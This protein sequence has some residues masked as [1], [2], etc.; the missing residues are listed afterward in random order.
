MSRISFPNP[1]DTE[2]FWVKGNLHTHTTNSDG[3]L[4]PFQT[5]LV[6]QSNGYG[7]LSITDHNKLTDIED[8]RSDFEDLILLPGEEISVGGYHLVAFNIKSEV[9]PADDPESVIREVHRQN[10]EVIVAHPYWSALMPSE[11]LELDGYLGIEVYNATCDVTVAKG[12][13]NVYWDILLHNGRFTYG[14][15]VDDAHRGLMLRGPTDACK[16]WIM[17]KARRFDATSIMESIRDGL[18]YSSTGPEIYDIQVDDGKIHVKTSPAKSISFIAKNG[19]GRRFYA[20]NEPLREAVYTVRGNEDYIRLEVEN[21]R[22][23]VAWTNP[24]I[25][26]TR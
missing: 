5:A 23:G 8:L 15:A 4:T 22:G 12:Y 21:E 14:F 7:F 3:L 17:V 10:G 11:L 20:L 18:F 24:M 6:Y 16:G 9:M 13:S 26:E 19:L 2:G 1:F 25:L